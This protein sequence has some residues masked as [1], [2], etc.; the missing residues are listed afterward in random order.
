METR[1][2]KES[3][4]EKGIG[5]ERGKVAVK[6]KAKKRKKEWVGWSK[7]RVFDGDRRDLLRGCTNLGHLG[8]GYP[9]Y[10]YFTAK[11]AHNSSAQPVSPLST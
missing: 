2:N 4:T 5:D 3:C 6:G 7:V 1:G 10:F 11:A 8:E 9:G